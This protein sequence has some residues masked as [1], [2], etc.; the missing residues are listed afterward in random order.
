MDNIPQNDAQGKLTPVTTF[1]YV[2]IDPETN[3]IRYVGK[4]DNPRKRLDGHVYSNKDSNRHKLNWVRKLARN[5]LKPVMQVI[6][7]TP[8]ELWKEREC[9]WIAYYRAQGCILL[10]VAEGG[11]GGGYPHTE[12]HN[13]KI[14]DFFRNKPQAPEHVEK[15]ASQHRGMKRPPES[16]ERS[17]SKH[18]GKSPSA[19]TPERRSASTKGKKRTP[20]TEEHKRHIS[21][22]TK[23]R[24]HSP[25]ANAKRSATQ[26]DRARPPEAVAKSAATRRGRKNAPGSGVNISL[27]K[28][29]ANAMKKNPPNAPTLWD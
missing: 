11:G 3:E 7:E 5:K 18:R 28:K 20:F 19:Q 1:I 29:R 15:R 27:G 22:A 12:E 14:G 25:E 17:A 6:E 8:Y 21:E 24:K 4:S 16:V 9:Y 23:H 2:L 26:K 10:N 13:R